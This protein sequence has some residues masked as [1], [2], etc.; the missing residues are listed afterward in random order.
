MP[1]TGM[2]RAKMGSRSQ[3]ESTSTVWSWIERA[4]KITKDSIVP[5]L[6]TV[7]KFESNGERITI[8]HAPSPLVAAHFDQSIVLG[9]I[10]N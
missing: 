3:V 4:K 8:V 5:I 10:S 2:E 7:R 9:Q 6:E 1:F